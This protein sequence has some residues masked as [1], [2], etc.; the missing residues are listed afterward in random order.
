MKYKNLYFKTL[1]NQKKERRSNWTNIGL[2]KA[3]TK[4]L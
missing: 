1:L 4:F 2:N 3:Q